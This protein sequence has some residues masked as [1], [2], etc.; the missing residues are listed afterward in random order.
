MRRPTF[1]GDRLRQAR[2]AKGLTQQ[3][4]ADLV[5]ARQHHISEYES[6]RKS[7]GLHMLGCLA[8]CLDTS[9]DWLMGLRDTP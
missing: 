4:L 5:P 8:Q 6:G 1:H 2:L 3:G 7:P 9:M